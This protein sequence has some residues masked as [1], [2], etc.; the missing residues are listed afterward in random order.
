MADGLFYEDLREPFISSDITA[1]TLAATNKALY[2]ASNFPVLGGQYF[3]RPGKKVRI[4]LFGRM[5][6]V[7]TPGNFTGGIYY[8]SGADAT[9]TLLASTAAVALVASQ[10]NV[11]WECDLYVHCRTTGSAGTLF[12]TGKWQFNPLVVASTAQPVMHPATAA[13]VSGAVDLTAT[14]NILSIQALRSGSTVETMQVHDMEV[15]ALN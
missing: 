7:L 12:V 15:H 13:A 5:T 3:A 11:S 10:T 14:T 2:P 6:T 1:V 4:R 9:G 8:G